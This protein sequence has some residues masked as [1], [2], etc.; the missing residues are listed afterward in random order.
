VNAVT[1]T[2]SV[3]AGSTTIV[4]HQYAQSG[5]INVS[6]D[7]KV[8]AAAAVASPAKAV[9]VANGGV[10][11]GTLTFPAPA[12]PSQG[13]SSF[14]LDLFPFPTG[15]GVWAGTCAAG[16]PTLYGLS[17]VT[18]SPAP[19]GTVNVTVRQPSITV[20][21]ATGV[22]SFGTYPTQPN[23]HMVYTS[24]D[25]GCGEK[26]SQTAGTG[27]I[28]PYPGMPYGNYKLCGDLSG[29]YAQRTPFANTTTAG[30]STTIPYVGNGVC[31]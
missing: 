4:P 1:A 29:Q 20:T 8:G 23:E 10:P 14:A 26:R 7:T 11:A 18:A 31:P 30:Q 22:P 25:A 27:G 21:A 9:M 17:A 12:S 3:T 19:G 28:V 24:T 5:R 16:N 13:S 15:Y 6:V 2:T